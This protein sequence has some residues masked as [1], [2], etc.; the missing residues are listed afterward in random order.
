V[1][2][3]ESQPHP[4]DKLRQLQRRLYL[5][6]KRSR[7]RRFHALYDRL[8]RPDVWWRAWEEGRANGGSAGVDGVGIEDVERGG[9]QGFLDELAADLQARRYRPKPVVRVYIPKPDGRQRPVGIPTVR[10]RVVQAA[11]KLV[12]EPVFEASFRDSSYGFRPKRDAGQAVRAVK[13]ALVGGWWVLDADIQECFDTI[14]HGQLLRLVQR[15]V[16]D[17]RVLKLIRQWLT[18]GVV[19][20]GRWQATAK[21]TPQGGVLSP[22]L[23]NI[24]LHGLDSWWEERYAGVGRLSR[25]ADDCVVVCRTRQQATEAREII[26]RLLAWLKLTRHPDKTRVVG[27]V[28]DGFDFLGFHFHKK[29]SKRTRRLVPYAWPSGKAMRGVRAKIRQQTERCR[30]R[31]ALAELV[32]GLNRVIR[33]WRNYFRVGNSTKQLAALDRYVWLRLWLFLRK[34]QGPR[35]HLRPEAYAAWLRRSG[36]ERFSPTGRGHVQPCRP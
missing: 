13:A 28:D 35:G 12:V 33:G 7:H 21:G 17:R 36:L 23:A 9:V 20:D 32:Q 8:V 6:A 16:S 22:L 1:H 24:Y 19:E 29:P 18:V 34:R 25:Y 2:A 10:D 31:V 15:R 30:L 5:A 3:R 26:G 27:M 14:D 11:C 4:K